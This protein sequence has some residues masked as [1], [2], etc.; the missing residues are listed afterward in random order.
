MFI[1]IVFIWE[2]LGWIALAPASAPAPEPI[3]EK[4]IPT[5]SDLFAI[6][7][8]LLALQI[9]NSRFEAFAYRRANQHIST[10]NWANAS[11]S[12]GP[13]PFRV[14]LKGSNMSVH[15]VKKLLQNH[16]RGRL[17]ARY[18]ISVISRRKNSY[19]TLDCSSTCVA[20]LQTGC[21]FVHSLAFHP[22]KPYVATGNS[23]KTTKLW[24]LNTD[25]NSMTCVCTLQRHSDW[26]SSIA[27]HPSAP[28]LVTGSNDCT[29]KLWL[30]NADY[31]AATCVYTLGRY[32]SSSQITFHPFASYFMYGDH[33]NT[34]NLYHLDVNRDAVTYVAAMKGHLGYVRCVAF[35]PSLPILVTGSDDNT[36]KLW[37]LPE[38]EQ[39]PETKPRIYSP[40]SLN[41]TNF[42]D[43]TVRNFISFKGHTGSV[44]SA[45]FH[46]SA[47]Y[48][49][50]GSNDN[51]AKLWLL[52]AD[53]NNAECVATL[54]GHGGA[55]RSVAFHPT[56]PVIVTSSNDG[57][58]KIWLLG[59][60]A[61]TCVAT[62]QGHSDSVKS[63][64]FHLSAHIMTASS[65]GAF[66]LWR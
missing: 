50:T 48:L 9:N 62:L 23:D 7:L 56:A 42:P 36:F 64:A 24:L 12:I 14:L 16:F 35:H 29:V 28:Y 53:C 41:Y 63:V 20:T 57:T 37:G 65:D 54:E 5:I 11:M 2:I 6:P 34:A 13:K 38:H 25:C 66:K 58:T 31:S 17:Y 61:P 33:N 3:V 32:C 4:T 45:A 46:Q 60:D 10:L 30:L 21:A 47:P 51:T 39:M 52:N 40:A 49:V 18:A 27:F 8:H 22:S 1:L 15:L 55:V 43:M 44:C 59:E 19:P 26:V